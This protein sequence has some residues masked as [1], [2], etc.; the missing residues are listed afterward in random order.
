M[1]VIPSFW[2]VLRMLGILIAFL[3]TVILTFMR[4]NCWSKFIDRQIKD[5]WTREARRGL[6]TL[7]VGYPLH[8]GATGFDEVVELFNK[9][10]YDEISIGNH[11]NYQISQI[12]KGKVDEHGERIKLESES[13]TTFHLLVTLGEI[14][15]AINS[16]HTHLL[17]QK[18]DQDTF[19]GFAVLLLG[20]VVQLISFVFQH[21]TMF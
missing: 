18:E 2:I 4:T 14:E 9:D 17:E 21:F 11:R 5:R 7:K 20:F 12:Q 6:K 19:Y 8:P 3:G 10:Q 13:G 16:H 15:S 1:F